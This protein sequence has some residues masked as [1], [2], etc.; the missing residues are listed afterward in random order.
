MI[1]LL[2]LI[3]AFLAVIIGNMLNG[4]NPFS[5]RGCETTAFG[6]DDAET[7]KLWS[8]IVMKEHPED[9]FLSSGFAGVWNPDQGKFSGSEASNIIQFVPYFENKQG[10]EVTITLAMDLEGEGA[11]PE[12]LEDNEEA[13]EFY[14]FSMATE[15]IG[16]AVAL[17]DRHSL[18]R[19]AFDVRKILADLLRRWK[20]NYIENKL[21]TALTTSPTTSRIQDISAESGAAAKVT[22]ST[23]E[24]LEIFA[25]DCD[26][27]IPAIMY[28]GK[29]WR[30]LLLHDYQ[31]KD[32]RGDDDFMSTL[33][34]AVVRGWD[35]PLFT[36]ADY[37]WSSL[38]IYRYGRI[39]LAS[40]NIAR[41][42]LLGAQAALV[43]Y[44]IPWDWKEAFTDRYNRIPC[45]STAAMLAVGKTV[46]N[47][48]D[49]ATVQFKTKYTG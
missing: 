6:T 7:V 2:A 45:I 43:G 42:L 13:A 16:N 20:D 23:L 18:K 8:E 33:Q 9:F 21:V 38:L 46:F 4:R 32:L 29:P 17:A 10:D 36:N 47:D 15:D 49:Y 34:N 3:I 40:G 11:A 37:V 41:G 1:Q 31:I 39:N 27:I 14:S 28:K 5:I 35:N 26:P 48:E 24:D 12:D 30:V 25:R 22:A 19:P 44:S